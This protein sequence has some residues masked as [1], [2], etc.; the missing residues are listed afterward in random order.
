M[1]IVVKR[2]RGYSKIAPLGLY[3]PSVEDLIAVYK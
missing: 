2:S 3:G 1:Y